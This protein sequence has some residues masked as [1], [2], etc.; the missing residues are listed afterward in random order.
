MYL[1]ESRR[2]SIQCS[3][4]VTLLLLFRYIIVTLILLLSPV[5][6]SENFK[7]QDLLI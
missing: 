7:F 6:M 4:V 5:N 3:G 1:T 2:Y